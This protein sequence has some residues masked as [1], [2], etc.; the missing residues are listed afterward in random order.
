MTF[1]PEVRDLAESMLRKSPKD[2]LGAVYRAQCGATDIN[3]TSIKNHPFFTIPLGDDE[4]GGVDMCIDWA[5]LLEEKACIVPVLDDPEDTSYFDDRTDRY[6]P[7]GMS[8]EVR[9]A[10]LDVEEWLSSGN[11]SD[12]C[13]AVL[14]PPVPGD[15]PEFQHFDSI[16]GSPDQRRARIKRFG[17]LTSL[18][19]TSSLESSGSETQQFPESPPTPR[20]AGFGERLSHVADMSSLST[21]SPVWK[22]PLSATVSV[23]RGV[24]AQHPSLS[25][26]ITGSHSVPIITDQRHMPGATTAD[27]AAMLK[28]R[29]TPKAP[30]WDEAMGTK[31]APLV[32]KIDRGGGRS[33]SLTVAPVSVVGFSVP[34][35]VMVAAPFVSAPAA[36][37]SDAMGDPAAMPLAT[38]TQPLLSATG[39]KAGESPIKIAA[40][41]NPATN[42]GAT[43]QAFDIEWCPTHH[44]GFRLRGE[45]YAHGKSWRHR[46]VSLDPDGPAAAAGIRNGMLLTM[47]GGTD[48]MK[49]TRSQVVR[50]SPSFACLPRSLRL[51][52]LGVFTVTHLVDSNPLSERVSGPFLLS[53]VMFYYLWYLPI[54]RWTRGG[55]FLRWAYSSLSLLGPCHLIVHPPTLHLRFRLE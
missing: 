8:D 55:F 42:S 24:T 2:R 13:D 7:R 51:S 52:P 43:P 36:S 38:P 27:T 32:E 48:T 21:S 54:P 11:E 37:L 35:K 30:A 44:L 18:L 12:L 10:S 6:L 23:V 4:E 50:S 1:S 3:S 16:S 26:Q 25:A 34:E 9:M 5:G 45:F 33:A 40:E 46:F 22:S 29:A 28:S 19:S 17:S 41:S 49:C 20:R 15:D 47:V 14:S 31:P 53:F 39:S